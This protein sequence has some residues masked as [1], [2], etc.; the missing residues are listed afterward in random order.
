MR[1]V[2]DKNCRENQKTHFMCS[3]F[4]F[5]KSCQLWDNMET[6]FRAGNFTDDKII[7]CV[8]IASWIPKAKNTHTVCAIR[9]AFSLEQRLHERD[10][11][12]CYSTL[13]CYYYLYGCETSF[14]KLG[15]NLYWGCLRRRYWNDFLEVRGGNVRILAGIAR[16]ASYSWYTEMRNTCQIHSGDH[17][18]DEVVRGMKIWNW[19]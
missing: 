7:W 2:L 12:L 19:C 15:K 1:N 9:I 4:F 5:R 18:P 10:S 17:K 8:H 16:L 14:L 11:L 13:S 6:C 3:D